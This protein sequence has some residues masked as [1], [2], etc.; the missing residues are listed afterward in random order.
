MLS[1]RSIP[2]AHV[3]PELPYADPGAAADWLCKAFGF[4][5]RLRIANH[6]IQMTAGD[7]AMIITELRGRDPE[8]FKQTQCVLVRVENAD[9]HCAHAQASG[10]RILDPPQDFPYGE[11]QYAA[12]DF[13][14]RRWR[15][16]QTLADVAPEEW[17]TGGEGNP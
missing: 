3:I 13:A 17:L 6:R 10:A 14:G 1:N 5:I 12:Q 2:T 16:T 11:R 15:F 7:G 4:S 8:M 9:A